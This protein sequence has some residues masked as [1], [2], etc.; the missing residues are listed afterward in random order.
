M[1]RAVGATCAG[2][3]AAV[4]ALACG[5]VPTNPLGVNF[6]S[7]V[8]TPSPSVVFGD[9]LRDSLGRAAPLRV[10]AFGRD[11]ADT[12]RNLTVRFLFTAVDTAASPA[13]IDQDGFLVASGRLQ[14]L[15][16]VG[17]VTDGTPGSPLRLQTTELTLDVVPRADSIARTAGRDTTGTG[18]VDTLSVTV[19][20]VG[21]DGRAP[22]AGLRVRYAIVGVYPLGATTAARFYLADDQGRVQ[23]RDSTHALDTT[24]TGGIASRIFVKL[25][26]PPG[27]P[28]PDSVVVEA[29]ATSH[30]N[31]P[32]RGAPVRF[33]LRVVP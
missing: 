11:S 21:P 4:I 24:S 30:A 16:I 33:T 6:I 18:L 14:T 29:T 3:L 12:V 31:E 19:T 13:R 8:I 1:R 15:R 28:N 20:G 32:L 10:F 7:A 2:M 25:L 27:Q 22:V 17:Q 23:G 9:T 5:D 26:A